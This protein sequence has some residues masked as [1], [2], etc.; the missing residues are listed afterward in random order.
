MTQHFEA[1]VVFSVMSILVTLFTWTYV[2]DPQPKIRLWLLGWGAIFVHFAAS[3]VGGWLSIPHGAVVWLKIATLE[4]AAPCFFLS[5]WGAFS[6]N[7]RKIWAFLVGVTLCS[8]LYLTGMLLNL[9][10]NWMYAT[11]LVITIATLV[12]LGFKERRRAT[13]SFYTVALLLLAYG[14]VA[15]RD[16]IKGHPL[17]GLYFYLALGFG[18]TGPAYWQHFRRS[19]P[20]VI[21]TSISFIAWG[22]VWPVASFL[23]SQGP[24]PSSFFWDLPKY[25]VAFGMIM[26]LFETQAEAASSSAREYASLFEDNLAAVYVCTKEGSLLDCNSAFLK[27]FGFS[28]KAEAQAAS[29]FDLCASQAAKE[30]FV[31]E[32][33]TAGVLLDFECQQHRKDGFLFWSLIR[34][35]CRPRGRDRV[36]Q[37]TLLDITERKEAELSIRDSE[38]RFAT[39]FHESPIG[40]AILSLDGKFL[41][42]NPALSR[43]LKRPIDEILGKTGVDLGFWRTPYDREIFYKQL[44]AEGAVQNFNIEFQDAEG[45]QRCGLYFA[46]IIR[47][48]ARECIL[49]MQSDQTELRELEAQCLQTQRMES[50]GRMAGGV[51]HDFN[52]VL[53]IISG[54][55]DLL[56]ARVNQDEIA[57]RYCSRI[58]DAAT[59]ANGLTRQLLTFS[60]REISR[61]CPLKPARVINELANILPRLLGEDIEIVFKLHSHST[62]VIDPT[63][64]EQIVFNVLVNARDAM[65]HG[66][67]I[68]IEMDDIS[69][70]ILLS[71]GKMGSGPYVAI[72]IRDTGIGMDE[73]TRL[74]AFEPFYTTK[75]M[76]RGTGLG[77]A[78]VYG[79]IQQC[80]GDVDIESSPGKGTQITI[81]LPAVHRA[82]PDPIHIAQEEVVMATGNILLVEDEEHLREASADY[83]GSLGYTVL[84]AGS[85]LEALSLVQASHAI[86]LVISDVVM[87]NMNGRQLA[88]KLREFRPGMQV[89]FISG[90]ADDVVL[91]AGVSKQG[92]PFLQKP[93]SLRTLGMKVQELLTNS[94]KVRV[95][96]GIIPS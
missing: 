59:R 13:P 37:A 56:G 30:R 65:P 14:G 61:P 53:G 34:A 28:S 45:R 23:G 27:M 38:E 83:L 55:A 33:E 24:A 74:H 89:L 51:A 11:F 93:F 67:Q 43:M 26:T 68:C 15:L 72:R 10:Q 66:G 18:L 8:V 95:C 78:T 40:C 44:R 42:V 49:G 29:V 57:K 84:C 88:E 48:G 69:H 47:I 12:P 92:T 7:I 52:N 1:V 9:S 96:S 3:L 94:K 39:I 17:T 63:Q 79:I 46:T 22:L 35:T 58:V 4:L 50:L 16:I 91:R 85:G 36:I 25:F 73:N 82:E 5:V 54:F 62:V 64:F 75:E 70:P 80:S 32:L 71:S 20:G 60:R 87:P 6:S 31:S 19:T 41:D 21:F 90:Y 2:R 76:G 86:D 81:L 77:L